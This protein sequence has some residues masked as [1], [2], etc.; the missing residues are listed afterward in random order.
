MS[1][2]GPT[3]ST[4]AARIGASRVVAG[5]AR[6]Q[7]DESDAFRKKQLN[8]QELQEANRSLLRRMQA[9]V[10]PSRAL[11]PWTPGAASGVRPS[12]ASSALGFVAL[13]PSPGGLASRAGSPTR[14]P[15]L[16]HEEHDRLS[17]ET[18]ALRGELLELRRTATARER[19]VQALQE[20]GQRLGQELAEARQ[21]GGD[22]A[23]ENETLQKAKQLL[24]RLDDAD[25]THKTVR[26][27]IE[28]D[29]ESMR[30][31]R[32]NAEALLRVESKKWQEKAE[33]LTA[34][35]AAAVEAQNERSS[36]LEILRA[37]HHA[38]RRVTE[39]D[40]GHRLAEAAH[41]TGRA[42]AAASDLRRRLA[43]ASQELAQ[44]THRIH[45]VESAAAAHGAEFETLR[46]E[47]RAAEHC[48]DQRDKALST[49]LSDLARRLHSHEAEAAAE[50]RRLHDS[51]EQQ[52]VAL[53]EE[54]K[55]MKRDATKKA[56]ELQTRCAEVES[57]AEQ[58]VAKA[59]ET[60]RGLL[61][62]LSAV[63]Q[64]KQRLEGKLRGQVQ[65]LSEEWRVER[66]ASTESQEI[67]DQWSEVTL[68]LAHA[69]D[70]CV[71]AESECADLRQRNAQTSRSLRQENEVL[72][73]QLQAAVGDAKQELQF[74]LSHER[75]RCHEE[76]WERMSVVQRQHTEQLAGM[77]DAR[78]REAKE[79]QAKVQ[80]VQAQMDRRLAAEE[81][82][83]A[84]RA[85]ELE[86]QT[87]T[88]KEAAAT[89]LG[90]VET[91]AELREE[92]LEELAAAR[93]DAEGAVAAHD[94]LLEQLRKE[95]EDAETQFQQVMREAQA[96]QTRLGRLQG[97]PL[98]GGGMDI[99]I[100]ASPFAPSVGTVGA[101]LTLGL[102]GGAASAAAA[103][104]ALADYSPR[105]PTNS[106]GA[107]WGGADIGIEGHEDAGADTL[108]RALTRER[109]GRKAQHVQETLS[110]LIASAG[111]EVGP[112]PPTWTGNAQHSLE[113]LMELLEM[114]TQV[115]AEDEQ[116]LMYYQ[117]LEVQLRAQHAQEGNSAK[118]RK[119]EALRRAELGCVESEMEA[120]RIQ[121]QLDEAR[122]EILQVEQT[123]HERAFAKAE[124][125]VG[126]EFKSEMQGHRVHDEECRAKLEEISAQHAEILAEETAEDREA[127]RCE[128][129]ELR[130]TL[131]R[132]LAASRDEHGGHA[133]LQVRLQKRLESLRD[134]Y[135]EV[136]RELTE[137]KREAK[138]AQQ[139]F[140]VER[141]K[142]F[143]E[144]RKERERVQ[145]NHDEDREL[146]A[147][148][149]TEFQEERI[150]LEERLS[151]LGDS[152]LPHCEMKLS[153]AR[154]KLEETEAALFDEPERRKLERSNLI[155]RLR[156]VEQEEGAAEQ[157]REEIEGH[158]EAAL[159]R[160]EQAEHKAKEQLHALRED[161][162]KDRTRQN[163][164]SER[165]RAR[166]KVLEQ[167]EMT[168]EK[169]WEVSDRH[170]QHVERGGGRSL[171]EISQQL[172]R[173]RRE[174]RQA[175]VALEESRLREQT[176]TEDVEGSRFA[177]RN[178]QDVLRT[179]EDRCRE[180]DAERMAALMSE[181]SWHSEHRVLEAKLASRQETAATAESWGQE[182]SRKLQEVESQSRMDLQ[183][184]AQQGQGQQLLERRLSEAS[185]E[186]ELARRRSNET[187][188]SLERLC[189][190][191]EQELLRLMPLLPTADSDQLS[192][193]LRRA[194]YAGLSGG[195]EGTASGGGEE[196]A[197]PRVFEAAAR[198]LGSLR[199][200]NASLRTAAGQSEQLQQ[201][202][203]QLQE[204]LLQQQ[205]QHQQL[206]EEHERQQKQVERQ[207]P[208]P[209]AKKGAGRGSGSES[210]QDVRWKLAQLQKEVI[211]LR[212]R[213]QELAHQLLLTE[214][215]AQQKLQQRQ[216]SG[217]PTSRSRGAASARSSSEGVG[218]KSRVVDGELHSDL[219]HK[220]KQAQQEKAKV[221]TELQELARRSAPM[222]A[223]VQRLTTVIWNEQH[224][225][226]EDQNKAELT[227]QT[228]E[229]RIRILEAKL[230]SKAEA[231]QIIFAEK[232]AIE[233]QLGMAAK[234]LEALLADESREGDLQ[235][236]L[237]ALSQQ[238]EQL[239]GKHQ[240]Q[241]KQMEKL[242]DL[243]AEAAAAK[244]TAKQL[245][246]E[247]SEL[248][249]AMTERAEFSYEASQLRENSRKQHVVVSELQEEVSGL[250]NQMD[251][252]R[253]RNPNPREAVNAIKQR[254]AQVEEMKERLAAAEGS[255]RQLRIEMRSQSGE[256]QEMYSDHKLLHYEA[257]NAR[258]ELRNSE[259][260]LRAF[261]VAAASGAGPG[262]GAGRADSGSSGR[263]GYPGFERRRGGEVEGSV[264][265][266]TAQDS[267]SDWSPP[268]QHGPGPAFSPPDRR[269]QHDHSA[270]YRHP[271]HSQQPQY[272][273][274][275]P[276][277]QH[278]QHQQQQHH[279][280]HQQHQPQHQAHD[281]SVLQA[282][283]NL[284]VALSPHERELLRPCGGRAGEDR[285]ATA[286]S[287]SSSSAAG[288][289]AADP[290]MED[291]ERDFGD[292]A[293]SI[294]FQG[295]IG[296]LWAE[297]QAQAAALKERQ[298]PPSVPLA[299]GA[300]PQGP[301]S[302]PQQQHPPPTDRR[303]AAV[304]ADVELRRPPPVEIYGSGHGPGYPMTPPRP[305]SPP[306]SG[307]SE[308]HAGVGAYPQS[309]GYPSSPG[310]G[311][312]D[313][314]LPGS[315]DRA[316]DELGSGSAPG[317]G[318][319]SGG[320]GNP[321]V[322]MPGSPSSAS[323]PASARDAFRRAE[324]YCEQ[325]RFAEAVPLFQQVLQMLGAGGSDGGGGGGR[326]AAAAAAAVPSAVIAEVWAHLGVAMQSLDRV[327]EAIES[328]RRA[329]RLDPTLHVCFAN[330]ATLHA[331][332]QERE[333]A[334]AYIEQA[335][336]LDAS[337]STYSQ[338]RQHLRELPPPGPSDGAAS[339]SEGSPAAPP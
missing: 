212:E 279:Q 60:E 232:E 271:Q 54:R 79:L 100:A 264:H 121:R 11:A 303:K 302:Q 64:E 324:A 27:Y 129:S 230:K 287:A 250:R 257:R 42:E 146:L 318:A 194:A 155:K 173:T 309:P 153:E 88:E 20:Q 259:E 65:V 320:G 323:L 122:E 175:D 68:E 103:G 241:G 203:L 292:F 332:L 237:A 296:P 305:P 17:A 116:Q 317:D 249:F 196:E 6:G 98:G 190:I 222:E 57:E 319:G 234:Q 291:I 286:A 198:Q 172:D 202:L 270:E 327:P 108:L 295:D 71:R 78:E 233:E 147:R 113:E 22:L 200:E 256:L 289:S 4:A 236:E 58:A 281:D 263:G 174:N 40:H 245:V 217:S 74:E 15:V 77:Q 115:A 285:G 133:Q 14:A 126:V 225:R 269:E 134:D 265:I 119:N 91:L 337:N 208:Q 10:T 2:S 1:G 37:D 28:N 298:P 243:E 36:E 182:L 44:A 166:V 266:L 261:R 180:L 96:K 35:F 111:R 227:T 67:L 330:L 306:G 226:E 242:K 171:E 124:N 47:L 205:Q 246:R 197:L 144:R 339:T 315:L 128:L 18:S 8:I 50:S 19:E 201:H 156:V 73:R 26:S 94:A 117:R 66:D 336:A 25:V 161:R 163:K 53:A 135:Q 178:L 214:Q 255:E 294:G 145:D 97:A 325:Q 157:T 322:G 211:K 216:G 184:K 120:G 310:R 326:E 300:P 301:P 38:H 32:R 23:D 308:E 104:A 229:R 106:Q 56:A 213:N 192:E 125:S 46:A 158:L 101:S 62:K 139:E 274:Q 92:L 154:V 328:Y 331:Y 138:E 43:V 34:E 5:D 136:S 276:Q 193:V 137:T 338:I 130:R 48:H 141:R 223:E 297:A 280:H 86:K 52:Q 314:W 195:A 140:E 13:D 85:A 235:R 228:L 90:E 39:E 131:A 188:R 215:N 258:E 55:R 335:L 29:L 288:A 204:Q 224:Q 282:L 290:S 152:Q 132:E 312:T 109:A 16:L 299:P 143:A 334:Q 293:R 95:H 81:A 262:Q 219:R 151:E 110:E 93:G 252:A 75:E 268:A 160:S 83:A 168:L 51:L 333:R 21:Q 167:A 82:K 41:Q 316:A 220:L 84:E 275:H 12:Q 170:R 118:L 89:H 9:P 76:A 206:M 218:V 127:F 7:A 102:F 164:D 244:A 248:Q 189:R 70:E 183:E 59:K 283:G 165:L 177:A 150:V 24:E 169:Q 159:E 30:A 304:A 31:E 123:F 114:T 176:L 321:D 313:R 311:R 199:Q 267:D 238:F 284:P 272:Q 105:S 277:Q 61:A 33:R 307:G 187:Q 186:V 251:Q 99:A 210:E 87:S 254:D 142:E 239:H 191:V 231:H 221:V 3:A 209:Q 72:V 240:A 278:Q 247:E 112:L 273:Q 181:H 185:S 260:A 253:D 69:Q 179:V 162:M 63:R 49:E 148:E 207:K 45:A 329:V 107:V 149:L 80:E